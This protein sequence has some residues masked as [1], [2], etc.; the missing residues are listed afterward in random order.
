M[1]SNRRI[2]SMVLL[3]SRYNGRR[4]GKPRDE[5]ARGGGIPSPPRVR[6][7]SPSLGDQVVHIVEVTVSG[8]ESEPVLPGRCRDPDVIFGNRAP[9]SQESVSDDTVVPRR[10]VIAYEHR[11]N[12]PQAL[13]TL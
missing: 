6:V 9:L 5:N 11:K 8:G 12:A 3:H 10:L 1:R 13:E 2:S 7:W 4:S